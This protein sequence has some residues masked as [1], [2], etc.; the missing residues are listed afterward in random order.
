MKRLVAALLCV[1]LFT[2]VLLPS[3]SAVSDTETQT[4]LITTHIEN[5]APGKWNAWLAQYASTAQPIYK[6]FVNSL[7]CQLG[8][9]G[10]L[11]VKNA[12]LVSLSPY[13][14][15]F[16]YH[17]PELESFYENKSNYECYLAEINMVVNEDNGYFHNGTNYRII[18][19]VK[20]NG[21]WKIGSE[22]GIKPQAFRSI[23]YGFITGNVQSPP[24][25]IKLRADNSSPLYTTSLSNFVKNT[26][27]CEVGNLNYHHN[28][29]AAIAISAKMFAWWAH[30]GSYRDNLSADLQIGNDVTYNP[31]LTSY[32]AAIT[33]AW[34]AVASQYILSDGG[35][36]F[37]TRFNNK[38]KYDYASSGNLVEEG[39]QRMASQ[40]NKTWQQI[41]Q[42]Y[43][44]NSSFNNP[45]CGTI[46]IGT[47]GRSI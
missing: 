25:S 13:S 11:T 26:V 33:T 2:S 17:Y 15:E 4:E 12:K 6:D 27:T 18:T 22:Y 24:A 41:V 31:S 39:A 20:E 30:L 28:A 14:K 43:F 46:I 37:S 45:N 8:N 38:T 29:L 42:H 44:N 21:T 16:V 32:S 9:Q 34:T 36:F 7:T 47:G 40:E 19:L 3:V 23:D 1:A 10:V 35:Q 5:M